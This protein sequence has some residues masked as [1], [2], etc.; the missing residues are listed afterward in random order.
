MPHH[1][2]MRRSS[3]PQRTRRVLLAA[4]GYF[5]PPCASSSLSPSPSS[6]LVPPQNTDAIGG[7]PDSEICIVKYDARNG[8]VGESNH[9]VHFTWSD[10]LCR[11]YILCIICPKA[12]YNF[13]F[14]SSTGPFYN[15][16]PEERIDADNRSVYVGNVRL[17]YLSFLHTEY[18]F[19][20]TPLI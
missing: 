11:R 13:L 18:V 5:L 14:V 9:C 19:F 10:P 12:V 15:M 20:S 2:P 8:Y 6:L 1:C 7:V 3:E 16:T 17:V 4:C